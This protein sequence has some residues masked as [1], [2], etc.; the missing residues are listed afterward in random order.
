MILLI[1]FLGAIPC[2][3]Y[4][5]VSAMNGNQLIIFGGLSSNLSIIEGKKGTKKASLINFCDNNLYILDIDPQFADKIKHFEVK[6]LQEEAIK[7]FK[8]NIGS[9]RRTENRDVFFENKEKGIVM[10]FDFD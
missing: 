1:I 9:K 5:H 3:R 6:R 10:A 8:G 2:K 4:S 7:A